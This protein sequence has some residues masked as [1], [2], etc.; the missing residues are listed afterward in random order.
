[1]SVMRTTNNY[2]LPKSARANSVIQPSPIKSVRGQANLGMVTLKPTGKIPDT[3][4]KKPDHSGLGVAAVMLFLIAAFATLIILA[5]SDDVKGLKRPQAVTKDFG[6]YQTSQFS[7]EAKLKAAEDI[8]ILK[9]QYLSSTTPADKK[10][11]LTQL[12]QRLSTIPYGVLPQDL[13]QFAETIY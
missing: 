10:K 6:Q 7:P 8:R 3:L 2:P 5:Y 1:M 4:L 12:H 11:V 13:Q 9:A